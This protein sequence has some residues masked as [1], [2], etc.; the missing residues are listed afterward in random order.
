[1]AFAIALATVAASVFADEP[2]AGETW[3]VSTETL[4]LRERP[5]ALSPA[6][7]SLKYNDAAEVVT[8]CRYAVPFDGDREKF[9]E[10]LLPLW[11]K[12]KAGGKTGYLPFPSLAS[13]WLMGN[14]NPNE[15]IAADGTFA[16]KRGFSESENDVALAS[17]RGFS[18]SE[19]GEMVAMRGAAGSGLPAR[20]RTREE[21]HAVLTSAAA[22]K[23]GQG[24]AQNGRAHSERTAPPQSAGTPG[25]DAG[26]GA[27][28]RG[29]GAGCA[30]RGGEACAPA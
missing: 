11:I 19:N 23:G 18:E 22:G 1:M 30:G 8:T 27:A 12:V 26:S 21:P 7:A 5:D 28:D 3:R 13:E 4:V 20:D 14:Q 16:A 9:P 6:L 15:T 29:A 24:F 10:T 17:M 2:K 25:A